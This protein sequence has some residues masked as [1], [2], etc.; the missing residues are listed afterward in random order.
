MRVLGV[1]LLSLAGAMPAAGQRKFH[2]PVA[3]Q[4]PLDT[5]ALAMGGTTAASREASA[6]LSN[7]ALTSTGSLSGF[8]LTRYD[9]SARGGML[10]STSSVGAIGVGVAV[11]YLDYG[12]GGTQ[13]SRAK[14]D[15]LWRNDAG[16]GASLAAAFALSA[17][18]K[19]LRW[20]AAA[21]YLEERDALER[22]SVMAVSVGVARD[23]FWWGTSLGVAVQNI[24]PSLQV[25]GE[26][27]PLPTRLSLGLSRSVFPNRSWLDIALA[28]GV[29]V[30]RDGFVSGMAGGEF[31]WVPIEGVSV[32]LRVGARRPELRAQRPLTTGVG[33]ALDRFALDYAWEQ[34]REGGAHRVG[35]RLR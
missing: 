14:D 8:A 13:S 32:A 25:T 30:R 29:A 16:A 28:G 27:T 17:S 7:P 4:S 10:G 26:N 18:F 35:I 22:A 33:I 5:R 1:V 11:S 6:A 19:G 21:T 23:A 2:A 9:G 3:A 12:V 34:L 31:A 15:G 24:G 20:G